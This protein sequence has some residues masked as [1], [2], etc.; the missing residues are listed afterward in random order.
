[1][2][3][4]PEITVQV[5]GIMVASSAPFVGDVIQVIEKAVESKPKYYG[6]VCYYTAF[7]TLD[8]QFSILFRILSFENCDGHIRIR[9]VARVEGWRPGR[10][11]GLSAARRRR[12]RKGEDGLGDGQDIIA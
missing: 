4:N 10:A 11:H 7:L 6:T 2:G 8:F 1:M 5:Q 9:G 3:V 12:R